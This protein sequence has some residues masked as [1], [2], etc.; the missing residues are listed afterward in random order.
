MEASRPLFNNSRGTSNPLLA[1]CKNCG[2]DE[3]ANEGNVNKSPKAPEVYKTA[4]QPYPSIGCLDPNGGVSSNIVNI[5]G[6]SYHS[7]NSSNGLSLSLLTSKSLG[8]C[9]ELSYS[10]VTPRMNGTMSGLEG[11]SCGSSRELSVNL[12]GN[13]YARFSLKV[14]GSRYLVGSQEILDQGAKYSFKNLKQ[15]SYLVGGNS[16]RAGAISF[17]SCWISSAKACC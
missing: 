2:Y 3:I 6:H 12:G 11:A 9:L 10:D 5:T 17:D 4:C 1:P 16:N 7:S 13:K 15:I 8:Q 14:S